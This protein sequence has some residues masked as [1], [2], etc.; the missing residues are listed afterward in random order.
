M[1]LFRYR[2]DFVTILEVLTST[3]SVQSLFDRSY[4]ILLLRLLLVKRRSVI[5]V[6]MVFGL[7]TVAI[8][9]GTL[10]GV[11]PVSALFSGEE[12]HPPALTSFESAG[13]QCTDDF[14]ANSSMTVVG[15]EANTQITYAR[16]VSL[17]GPSYAIGGPT[18]ERIN[19][20]TYRLA[21]PLE[22]TEKAPRECSG[23]A[24]YNASMR[25]PSSDDPWRV[26]VN[27]D[28]KNITTLYGDSDGSIVGSSVSSG[29]SASE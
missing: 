14:M 2:A 21:I 10:A 29:A 18:F 22:E 26:I 15:G 3:G 20:S 7:V 19:D 4:F 5:A 9:T 13:A 17:P 6:C 16:N 8:I 28:G 1:Y 24:R 11:G 27:H 23:V 25:I 12:S